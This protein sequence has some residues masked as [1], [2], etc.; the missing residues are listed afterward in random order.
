MYQ[1][2]KIVYFLTSK[3][4]RSER[5]DIYA[6][7]YEVWSGLQTEYMQEK[8]SV[9]LCVSVS[10]GECQDVFPD[11]CVFKTR[12]KAEGSKVNQSYYQLFVISG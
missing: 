11:P 7:N 4:T 6:N 12:L 3:N 8:M 9:Y 5:G 2:G 1:L 10:R